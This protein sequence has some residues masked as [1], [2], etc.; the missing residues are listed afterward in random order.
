MFT[1]LSSFTVN[2]DSGVPLGTIRPVVIVAWLRCLVSESASLGRGIMK[3]VKRK[4]S[5]VAAQTVVYTV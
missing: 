3:L 1:P 4:S 5:G 2:E